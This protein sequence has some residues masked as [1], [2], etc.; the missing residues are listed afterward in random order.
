MGGVGIFAVETYLEEFYFCSFIVLPTGKIFLN[1]F[2]IN[3]NNLLM[4]SSIEEAV[5][6]VDWKIHTHETFFGFSECLYE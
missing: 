2:L 5:L 6:S 4:L 1:C 3:T